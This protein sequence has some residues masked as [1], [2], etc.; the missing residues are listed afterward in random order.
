MLTRMAE[1]RGAASVANESAGGLA[2]SLRPVEATHPW[3]RRALGVVLL[4]AAYRAVAEL[5]YAL[6]FA[7]PIAAIAWLPVGVGIAFLSLG[8]LAYW[9]GVLVGDLLA[10]DYSALPWGTA[11]AQSLG[12]VLEVVVAVVLLRRLGARSDPLASVRAVALLFLAIA[13]GTAV[14]ATIGSAASL[15]GEVISAEEV[16]R[17]WRTWWLGDFSGALIV[18]PLVLAWADARRPWRSVRPLELA[19]VLLA[20]AV[21]SELAVRSSDTLS[22][23]VLPVLV[24]SALRLGTRGATIAVAVAAA[25]AIWETTRRVGPFAS[26]SI[27]ESVLGTQLYLAVST[28]TTLCVAAVVC[29][30]EELA[31][32]LQ[33]SRA[34][35]VE[36]GT[37]ERSRIE[38]NLHDGA[39]QRLVALAVRLGLAAERAADASEESVGSLRRA[40]TEVVAAI[41]ELRELAHGIQPSLLT[42]HGLAHALTQ[43]AAGSPTELRL[44]EL[45]ATRVDPTAEVTAYF[46]VSEAVANARKYAR[47]STIEVRARSAH[48][49]LRVEIADDGAGGAD[50]SAGTGLQGLRDR[51]EAIGGTFAVDSPP[52]RGTRIVALVPASTRTGRPPGRLLGS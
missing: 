50:E 45:P 38:Q 18:L 10:N 5:G 3:L 34:R 2:L 12:N 27:T 37:R 48:G 16:P 11:V 43:L 26:D 25:F 24:W 47:A 15:A 19:A 40:E 28:L 44:A 1:A 21:L 36:A 8:G 13:A 51:V 6:Q 42:D 9:P 30:R 46:V 22:Y 41:D 35:I 7:G 20:L 33:A 49:R 31:R 4:A 39:Q 52:R 29:E 23:V 14:S 17:V 32:N